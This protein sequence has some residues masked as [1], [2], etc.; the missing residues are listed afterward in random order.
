MTI[1]ANDITANAASIAALVNGATAKQVGDLPTKASPA[2]DDFVHLSEKTTKDDFKAEVQTVGG[3]SKPDLI[4]PFKAGSFTYP[5]ANP[6]PL[7][8]G[9]G[10]Y[11]RMPRH[12]F[13]DITD[14]TIENLLDCVPEDINPAGTVKFRLYGNPLTAS[15]NN[16]LFDFYHSAAGNGETWDA[17]Y[18]VVSSGAKACINTTNAICIFEW[19]ETVANLGWAAKNH[20]RIKLTR[21]NSVASNLV[22][23]FGFT[24][25]HVQI[26]RI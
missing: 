21:N 15:T 10:T 19:T 24:L 5:T 7:D 13:D 8:T 6:A 16:V 25:F 2:V 4:I 26:P 17:D 9:T 20:V 12:L 1:T 11:G 14:Q 22:G 23:H 18:S 3:G